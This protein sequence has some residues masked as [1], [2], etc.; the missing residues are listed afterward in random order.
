MHG[1]IIVGLKE[2]ITKRFDKS[3]WEEIL[4]E[5]GFDKN[6][7]PLSNRELDDELAIRLL[8]TSQKK[9]NFSASKFGEFFG[10]YWINNFARIKFFA[11]FDA[12]KSS[13]D[14]ISNLSAMHITLTAK[15]KK[16]SPPQFIVKWE[17]PLTAVIEYKSKRNFIQLATGLLKAITE[18]YNEEAS[19]YRGE[20][21]FIRVI[22]Q[23]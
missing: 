11:F 23:M 2:M 10:S 8:N 14:F 20:G 12:Y 22:Y 18:Y 19:V 6:Y 16:P 1:A 17:N 4:I 5:A 21:N 3:L 15:L 13:K 9:L 7:H